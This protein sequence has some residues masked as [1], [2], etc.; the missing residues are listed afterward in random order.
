MLAV[1]GYWPKVITGSLHRLSLL[2]SFRKFPKKTMMSE[3]DIS[4]SFSSTQNNNEGSHAKFDK[5]KT[6]SKEL[7]IKTSDCRSLDF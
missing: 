6:D 5:K 7:K 4:F 2:P 1:S 3:E